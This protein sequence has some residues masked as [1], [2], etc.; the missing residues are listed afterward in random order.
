MNKAH[1]Y[2]GIRHSVF[3]GRLGQSAVDNIEVVLNYW[4]A[5]FSTNPPGQ[6]AYV[7]ATVFAEVGKKMAPV[8]EGFKKTDKE[9]RAHV[10]HRPYGKPAGPGKKHVYYGRGYVQLT[11]DYNYKAQGTKLGVD[12][13]NKP[14][15]ALDPTNAVQILVRGMLDGDFNKTG[16]GLGDYVTKTRNDFTNARQTVNNGDR[17]GEIAGYATKFLRAIE[18]AQRQAA[19]S[20]RSPSIEAAKKDQKKE[21]FLTNR[22]QTNFA[23]L[24]NS[25]FDIPFLF[26]EQEELQIFLKIIQAID[27]NIYKYTPREIV[28]VVKSSDNIISKEVYE[29][30][31]STLA[32]FLADAIPLFFVPTFVKK[33]IIEYAIDVI[34][35]ALTEYTTIDDV[36]LDL[37]EGG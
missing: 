37:L 32:A 24:L 19:T 2:D 1:F 36:I 28:D 29:G 31:T 6:L 27:R 15:L 35:T 7:L 34:V 14:D 23:I 17:A 25:K 13:L 18:G 5:N 9:A 10:S 20:A 3:G 16:K 4:S 11:W 22:Q 8:R 30:L 12:L 26:S 33:A 21:Y